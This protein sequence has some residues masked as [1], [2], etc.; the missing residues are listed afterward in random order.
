MTFK[1]VHL[2]VVSDQTTAAFQAALHRFIARRNCPIHLYSD[3]GPNFTGAKNNLQ[4]L[5][6]FLKQ[7]ESDEEIQHFLSTHHQIT[8]HNSPPRSPHFGGLWESAVKGM[9]R[10]LKKVMGNTLLT[11]E[12]MTTITCQVEACMNSRPLLPL[13]SHSQDG[14]ATL[15]ASHFLLFR[16]PSAYPE[17]PRLPTNP[18]LLRRW[19]QCQAI[20]HHFWT[21]WSKEY[22]NSLQARTKWQTKRPNMEPEDIVILR[23]EKSIFSCHWPLGRIVEVFPGKDNLVRVVLVKTAS[24]TYKRAVTRL[25]LLFRPS[26]STQTPG[27]SSEFSSPDSVKYITMMP[28]ADSQ[29]PHPPPHPQP[30]PPGMCPVKDTQSTGQP[31]AAA[32]QPLSP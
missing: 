20:V 5:Y 15:T 10:H 13:T 22:L 16:S 27:T 25:S 30:L 9:K 19:N 18:H 24:G 23:P 6:R 7:Q 21:R 11:F 1:A 29:E 12:E 14:L 28:K 17:D 26:E 8:W 4:Q 3:N 2:E 31:S 32:A